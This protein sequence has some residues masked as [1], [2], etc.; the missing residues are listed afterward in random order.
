M[1][2]SSPAFVFALVF[3]LASGPARAEKDSFAIPPG[4][5][6]SIRTVLVDAIA[7]AGEAG[8]LPIE[9][10]RK[11]DIRVELDHFYV[12]LHALEDERTATLP[13]LVVFHPEAAIPEGASQIGPG[14]TL[15]CGDEGQERA[16][17]AEELE[18]WR[19][20]AAQIDRRRASVAE[21]IWTRRPAAV[22]PDPE[23]APEPAAAEEPGGEAAAEAASAPEDT[24]SGSGLMI[25]LA[26][27][28]V[29]GAGLAVAVGLRRRQG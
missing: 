22:A 11:V 29:V 6:E 14:V 24:E 7:A 28:A 20:L 15:R 25:P 1:S 2:R 18:P 5:I 17:E 4:Q 8:K 12:S 9:L 21:T 27:L 19:E 16:C 13:H 3:M 10:N 26:G 23:P